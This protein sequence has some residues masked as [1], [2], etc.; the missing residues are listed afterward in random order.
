MHLRLNGAEGVVVL[1]RHGDLPAALLLAHLGLEPVAEDGAQ[2][3]ALRVRVVGEDD[4]LALGDGREH[5]VLS[6]SS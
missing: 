2:E 4:G 1:L 6:V 5:L 3:P